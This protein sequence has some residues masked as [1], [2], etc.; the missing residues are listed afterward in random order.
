M[1][2]FRRDFISLLWIC[3]K[4]YEAFLSDSKDEK[5]IMEGFWS[6]F[7]GF[8]GS[9]VNCMLFLGDSKDEKRAFGGR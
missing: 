4:L 7:I 6:D 8:I 5:K 1:E 9:I 3:R 2:G